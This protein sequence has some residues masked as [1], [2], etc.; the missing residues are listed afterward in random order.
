MTDH[1]LALHESGHVV[2]AWALGHRNG[3]VTIERGAAYGGCTNNTPPR[4]PPRAFDRLDPGAS[5]VMWPA[6]VRRGIERRAMV[7]AA[8]DLAALHLAADREGRQPPPVAEQA[9]DQLTRRERADLERAAADTT[10]PSD[11]ANLAEYAQLM[12]GNRV[13]AAGRWL[14]WIEAETVDL[15]RGHAG[16]VHRLAAALLEHKT[17]SGAAVR[18]I[19]TN[20]SDDG[21]G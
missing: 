5:V 1:R 8:G 2:A 15:V 11:A 19:L 20:G 12:F 7:S 4:I 3:W 14:E 18:R 10:L 21:Q 16:H 9:A 13:Q 6:D 17:L